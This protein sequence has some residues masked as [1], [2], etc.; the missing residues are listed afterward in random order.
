MVQ[1]ATVTVTVLN[2]IQSSKLSEVQYCCCHCYCC[3]LDHLVTV[4]A[5]ALN[6]TQFA[7]LK[8]A[9]DS[10]PPTETCSILMDAHRTCPEADELVF[11]SRIEI[12]TSGTRTAVILCTSDAMQLRKT[13]NKGPDNGN[14]RIGVKYSITRTG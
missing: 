6:L 3:M 2:L 11:L 12:L 5:T 9:E 4:T 1:H 14:I 7:T 8:R 13:S 10:V